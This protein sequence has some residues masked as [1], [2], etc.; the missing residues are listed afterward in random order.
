MAG[1]FLKGRRLTSITLAV[2][3]AT[4]FSALLRF[5]ITAG[6][7]IGR[8]VLVLAIPFTVAGAFLWRYWW[9]AALRAGGRSR[10]MVIVGGGRAVEELAQDVAATP[11]WG[12]EVAAVVRLPGQTV[13]LPPDVLIL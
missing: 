2:L 6:P 9:A 11:T 4:A 12:C 13:S 3:S 5:F 1:P 10:R 7:A 8:V